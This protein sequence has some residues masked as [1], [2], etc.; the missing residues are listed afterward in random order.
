[1]VMNWIEIFNRLFEIINEEGPNYF[2]GGRF[3]SVVKEFEPYFPEYTQYIDQRRQE[4]KSTSRKDY[5]RD[6]F[7]S[8]EEE[9]RI[10]FLKRMLQ[11]TQTHNPTKAAELH[12]ILAGQS[13]APTVNIPQ[14]VW[15]ADRLN[16]YL[17]EIDAS[18]TKGNHPRA[19]SLSYTCLEGFFKAFIERNIPD[20]K[21][22]SELI[23][24]AREIQRYLRDTIPAY[25]DEALKLLNHIAHAVD[26]T[27]NGFSES[28]FGDE[29][30]KWLSTFIRDCTNSAIRL[31]LSFM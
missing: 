6:I 18:I 20:R 7:L 8:F 15:S 17:E 12:S 24:M 27:R 28:H 21:G 13:V 25:P 19:I 11:E 31:L 10:G 30:E 29:A 14:H 1:M 16:R 9:Q 2:S 23:A 4:N 26:K 22:L 5:Y 3:I